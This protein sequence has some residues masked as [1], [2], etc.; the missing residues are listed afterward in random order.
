MNFLYQNWFRHFSIFF[1]MNLLK[2]SIHNAL[3]CCLHTH[4]KKYPYMNVI[5]SFHMP[6][7]CMLQKFQT[8][9]NKRKR[10]A[11]ISSRSPAS[12]VCCWLFFLIIMYHSVSI[13]FYASLV[14]F[15]HF[16]PGEQCILS[17][18]NHVS[19]GVKMFTF[20]FARFCNSLQI[21]VH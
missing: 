13:E 2:F 4:T 12:F 17:T 7:L 15:V 21:Q 3:K 9:I 10:D 20:S 1:S 5:F 11:Y 14:L 19:S 18:W 6:L 8:K 16:E